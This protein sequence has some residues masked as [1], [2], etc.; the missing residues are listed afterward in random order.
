MLQLK[1][2]L[3]TANTFIIYLPILAL[4]GNFVWSETHI[5]INLILL[6]IN[7]PLTV[8]VYGR[9]VEI[10]TNTDRKAAIDILADNWWNY[11]VTLGLL[12]IP[13][14]PIEL[15]SGK[16]LTIV[17]F[18]QLKIIKILLGVVIG[19]AT[20]YVMPLVFLRKEI[21]S[22]ITFGISKLIN[23]PR[24]SIP[25][26]LIVALMGIIK[27]SLIF[28]VASLLVYTENVPKI[29]IM[30]VWGFFQ[31]ILVVYLDLIL[32]PWAASILNEQEANQ[33]I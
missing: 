13:V 9:I 28:A 2:S 5:G 22:S 8:I 25:L 29:V 15:L 19:G 1:Q 4:T 21:F 31:N 23:N 27:I 14:L 24:K 33:L 18:V 16:Y 10:V 30:F 17:D 26:L 32:F 12:M 6:L 3:K 11:I 20:L 7:L